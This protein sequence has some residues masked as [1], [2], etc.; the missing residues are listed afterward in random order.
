[1]NTRA[2]A[3]F[4]AAIALAVVPFF[5][6]SALTFQLSQMV[7]LAIALTGLNIFVGWAGQPTLAQGAM[8]AL[9]AYAT[10]ILCKAGVTWW[11]AL[12]LAGLAVGAFA[13]LLALPILRLRHTYLA[14][15]TFALAL[16]VPQVLKHPALAGWTGGA[17]G[18]ELD[19]P[20]APAWLQLDVSADAW[21][22]WVALAVA[23][24]VSV[25]VARVLAGRSGLA[26]RAV[27]DNV[28]A[29]GAQGI[30]VSQVKNLAFC[31]SGTL[32]ALGGGLYALN[33]QYIG[34]E[35][36]QVFLSLTMLAALVVGG[37]GSAAGPWVG[38]A[39][40]QFVPSW[41]EAISTSAPW[42]IFG[43]SVLL[44]VFVAPKG[45]AGSWRPLQARLSHLRTRGVAVL[46]AT[47]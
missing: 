15:A 8:F 38:A 5:V 22:Y 25:L 21:M 46:K 37:P 36:F 29:A 40:L 31:A 28:F 41:A 2:A 18:L 1:M 10:A 20:H 42:A 9:G 35:S 27:R 30:H 43:F 39:L 23:V 24:A 12:P 32:A 47:R 44:V 14:L 45:I 7:G 19:R 13:M 4:A 16:A 11:L 6:P 34:P 26:L 17:R 3:V 33:V